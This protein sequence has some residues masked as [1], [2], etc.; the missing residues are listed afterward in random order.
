MT[1]HTCELF[2]SPPNHMVSKVD[3]KNILNFAHLMKRTRITLKIQHASKN[4][5]NSITP[6]F[7]PSWILTM[8]YHLPT[9]TSIYH[10]EAEQF[11]L[12]FKR[13]SKL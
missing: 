9:N 2:C 11:P 3:I 10:S 12:S 1:M 13:N 5:G 6:P 7:K 8:C 4:N